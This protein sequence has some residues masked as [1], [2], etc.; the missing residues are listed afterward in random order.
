MSEKILKVMVYNLED[1]DQKDFFVGVNGNRGTFPVATELDLAE[2]LV[3]ALEAAVIDTMVN[4]PV[5]NKP[6]PFR[7]ERFKVIRLGVVS[8]GTT[9][10]QPA[11]IDPERLAKIVEAIATIP[12]EN[13]GQPAGGRPAM[14]KVGDVSAILGFKVSAVEITAAMGINE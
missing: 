12:I 6:E 9:V 1:P 4:N 3:L 8:E 11:E 5:T 7:K 14:P 2:P 10:E 13:Y